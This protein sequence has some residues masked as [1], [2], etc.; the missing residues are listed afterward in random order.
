MIKYLVE[1]YFSFIRRFAYMSA[2]SVSAFDYYEFEVPEK[3]KHLKK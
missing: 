1:K 3:L 2:S